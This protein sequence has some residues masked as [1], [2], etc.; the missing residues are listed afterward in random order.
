MRS[1]I[2]QNRLPNQ[3]NLNLRAPDSEVG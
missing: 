1:Q 3:N 2:R